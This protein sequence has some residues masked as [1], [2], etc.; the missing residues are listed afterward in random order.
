V[1]RQDEELSK[2]C[3]N[4]VIAEGGVVPFIQQ[5]L[6]PIKTSKKTTA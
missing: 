3:Q 5:A 6:L 2:L 1:V 4:V